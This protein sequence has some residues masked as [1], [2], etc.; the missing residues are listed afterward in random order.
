M[1][2][3]VYYMMIEH[4]AIAQFRERVNE[5]QPHLDEAYTAFR[6]CVMHD[7]T[8]S[9]STVDIFSVHIKYLRDPETGHR[10][11]ATYLSVPRWTP[12]RVSG[13]EMRYPGRHSALARFVD[14]DEYDQILNDAPSLC[15]DV[16]QREDWLG[17]C[18]PEQEEY[19]IQFIIDE[20]NVLQ[21]RSVFELE[22]PR[23]IPHSMLRHL[24][25]KRH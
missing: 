13:L 19:G 25:G 17:L 18:E 5:Y 23:F 4:D 9:G 1:R 11:L 7:V 21:I 12:L 8:L 16:V 10:R 24:S 2:K 3:Y 6:R 20:A 14:P 22:D 15:A